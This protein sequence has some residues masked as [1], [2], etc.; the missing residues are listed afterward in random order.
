MVNPSHP[1]YDLTPLG[2]ELPP[3]DSS[4]L[5]IMVCG[6]QAT[7]AETFIPALVELH[8]RNPRNPIHAHILNPREEGLAHLTLLGES[9]QE[10]RLSVTTEDVASA[11]RPMTADL[12]Y[13]FG[14]V[15]LLE[16]HG[17]VPGHYGYLHNSLVDGLP[18]LSI[19]RDLAKYPVLIGG[20]TLLGVAVDGSEQAQKVLALIARPLIERINTGTVQPEDAERALSSVKS[21][22]TQQSS[23]L[24]GTFPKSNREED[25]YSALNQSYAVAGSQQQI[26]NRLWNKR[27]DDRAMR[28]VLLLKP[29]L[30]LPF[31]SPRLVSDPQRRRQESPFL[32]GSLGKLRDSWQSC[33]NHLEAALRKRGHDPIV[34]SRPGS[35]ITSALANFSG[36][37]IVIMPHRQDFQCHGLLIPALYLM[38]IAHRWLFTIDRKGWGAGAHA[39]PY[40]DFRH[41]PADSQ[42]YDNYRDTIASANE[43]KFDQ[44]KRQSKEKLITE[45]VLPS[46]EYLFFPCQI[47]DDEVVR[48]FCDYSEEDVVA[49]LADWA[50]AHHVNI[51]F[52]SH[53]AAPD[54]AKPFKDLA[55]GPYVHWVDASIHDL[56]EHCQAVYTLNSG[57]GHEAILHGKPVVMFG[58]AEY[59]CVVIRTTLNQLDEAYRL[60]QEWD[61]ESG[62]QNYRRFYHW[63]TRNVA[64]DLSADDHLEQALNRVI[65]LIE[66]L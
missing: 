66:A 39:Y 1:S 50:N 2:G 65:D 37:D 53:P 17:R 20:G 36:A 10:L 41:S 3:A 52:K 49:A 47:P 9:H 12:S 5:T 44:P 42:V 23:S 45:S 24:V 21:A 29:D 31:K 4:V 57:A 35:E 16:I 30:A 7:L 32:T 22:L 26:V 48:F 15:R 58:R 54:T 8:Q 25:S 64:I 27:P 18:I 43:S 51:I 63:F 62:L 11:D 60:V 34:I 59:D 40:E 56:I 28:R 6:A 13:L 46:E 38:Q 61:Q 19:E 14:L 55:R 33:I